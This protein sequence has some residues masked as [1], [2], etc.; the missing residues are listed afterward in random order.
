MVLHACPCNAA[1]SSFGHVAA[2]SASR[3]VTWNAKERKYGASAIG[4]TRFGRY[5]RNSEIS[6][7][8]DSWEGD[9]W[10]LISE[11]WG[12]IYYETGVNKRN[13]REGDLRYDLY[14][15]NTIHS[16]MVVCRALMSE[17]ETRF[18]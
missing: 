2:R 5:I 6:K 16:R 12:T 8:I 18:A 14:R 7:R 17:H 10:G 13:K 1:A 11:E 9:I 15:V 3:N 4:W